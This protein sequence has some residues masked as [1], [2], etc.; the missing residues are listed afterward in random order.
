[1]NLIENPPVVST[2][3]KAMML[4]CGGQVVSRKELLEVPTPR[5]TSTWFPMPHRNVLQEIETQLDATGFYI[6]EETHALSHDGARYFGVLHVSLSGRN[7]TAQDYGW[8]VGLRNS[9]DMTYPAGLV[10]GT[11]V[12]VCDNLAF[13]GE[14]RI[15]R[16]HTKFAERDLRPLTARA[17]GQLAERFLELDQR[18][19]AYK[20][21]VLRDPDVH[22]LVIRAVDAGALSNRSIPQVLQEWR[23][24]SH[25]EFSEPTCWSLFNAFTEVLKGNLQELPRRTTA[26]HGLFDTKVGL[27]LRS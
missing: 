26:L 15:S 6:E 20:A 3:P 14:V 17:V 19:A 12:F 4:H 9:H 23:K 24:P 18:I 10:A 7:P 21:R 8:V 25:P 16:K 2:Q 27:A 1:M 13:T 11:R 22:D 5:A